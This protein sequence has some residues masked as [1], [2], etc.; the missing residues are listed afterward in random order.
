MVR[1]G[2]IFI[3]KEEIELKTIALKLRDFKMK[4]IEKID[5][6]E[7]ELITEINDLTITTNTLRGVFS[8]DRVLSINRRG[9]SIPVTETI[10]A[11]IIFSEYGDRIFLTVLE[12]K[13]LANN[14]A[15]Q[16]SK[17]IFM[18]TGHIV[19][20]RIPSDVMR[21]FHEQNF[22]DTKVVFFDNVDIPNIKK[23][24]LYGSG[25]ADTSLYSDYCSH[26]SVWYV[27][28][29]PKK[30]GFVVGVTRNAVVTIF[31]NYNEEDFMKYLVNEIYHLIG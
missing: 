27:V 25:L 8:Q 16:L 17:I 13:L 15:N 23:L 1:A 22:E 21:S 19:E 30:Y 12:K 3:I 31:G 2:K 20:A 28:I 14:I 5:D 18:T 26:G 10:D 11:S 4:D 6:N 9:G 24:S 7:F 29:K